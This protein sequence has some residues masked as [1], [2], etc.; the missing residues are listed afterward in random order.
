MTKS[1]GPATNNIQYRLVILEDGSYWFDNLGCKI[2]GPIPTMG[3][4][5]NL[6]Y[7][8]DVN[9][10]KFYIDGQLF[11][12]A[13][14]STS[15]VP[16]NHPLIIGF[17]PPVVSEYF[18]GAMDEIRIYSRALSLQEVG[19]LV[20]VDDI[21]DENSAITTYPNPTSG[22][23]SITLEEGNATSVAIRNSLGQILLIDKTRATNQ[24]ELDI[25]AYPTGLYFLQLEVDGQL[26]TKKIVKQ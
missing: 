26:M 3:A 17:D 9:D 7:V 12:T 8:E 14:C 19:L 22:K 21:N 25:S 13:P 6:T 24:L 10:I 20:G 1:F 2:F 5:Y 11:L 23:L 18:R 16:N 15:I 4:W